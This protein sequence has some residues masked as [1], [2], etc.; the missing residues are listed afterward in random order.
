VLLTTNLIKQT[1]CIPLTADEQRAEDEFLRRGRNAEDDTAV[2]LDEGVEPT[3][4]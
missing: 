3:D 2:E 1:L 4:E